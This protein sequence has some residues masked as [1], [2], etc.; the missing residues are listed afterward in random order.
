MTPRLAGTALRR[1]D[2]AREAKREAL[3]QVRG[4][5]AKL[6]QRPFQ[7]ACT[8]S[9]GCCQF[10]VTG[11]VPQLTQGEALVAAQAVRAAG[12][13]ALP[14]RSDGACPLLRTDGRC[15]IYNDRPFGCRTHF[16]S[17]AGGPVGRTEVLDLIRELEVIDQQLGGAGPRALESTVA[18]ELARAR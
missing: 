7:R 11:R 4:I 15:L 6:G 12:R 3:A 9:T 10:H 5:Y 14:E 13:K 16:C 17:A 18:A 2:P 8:S 1:P